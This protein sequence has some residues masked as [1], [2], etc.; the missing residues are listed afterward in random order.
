MGLGLKQRLVAKYKKWS[1]QFYYLKDR[2]VELGC[3]WF[4]NFL[5]LW[6]CG[7]GPIAN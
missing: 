1:R 3:D 5:Y 6:L 7:M 4:S 2:V